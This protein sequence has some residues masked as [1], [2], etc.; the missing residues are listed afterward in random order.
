MSNLREWAKEIA[1]QMER[2]KREE[3][4]NLSLWEKR[5]SSSA[6]RPPQLVVRE[7][8]LGRNPRYLALYSFKT[9]AMVMVF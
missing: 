4:W 7:Y 3:R 5:I 8:V 9:T 6:G 1:R 2:A